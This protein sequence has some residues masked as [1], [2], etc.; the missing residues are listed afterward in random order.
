MILKTHDLETIYSSYKIYINDGIHI[1]F[2]H[3][4]ILQ[5]DSIWRAASGALDAW[6]DGMNRR[7]CQP[8]GRRRGA[9]MV[10]S[11]CKYSY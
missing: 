4:I 2:S 9:C 7:T 3:F 10:R 6:L 5:L 1:D 11:A 8:P